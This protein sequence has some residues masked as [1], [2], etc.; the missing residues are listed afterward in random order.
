M[1]ARKEKLA[2]I[3]G[4]ELIQTLEGISEYRL[5]KNGLRI[6]LVPDPAQPVAGCMVTYH[7]GSRN[8]ATGYTGATHLLEHLMFKGSKKFNRKNKNT[9]FELLEKKGAQVNATTW[10]DRTNYYEIFPRENLETAIAIEADRMRN[11]FIEEK[12]RQSEMT[13][14]RNE[15]ESGENSP[16]MAIDKLMWATAFQAHPYHHPT[17]GWKSDIE[18][19]PIERLKQFYDEF[20]WP[21]NATLTIAGGFDEAKTLQLIKKHFGVHGRNPEPSPALYTQEPPQEGQ[22]RVTVERPGFN[23]FSVAYR[24]PNAHH[25]DIP[26]IAMLGLVLA[27]G[28]TSRLYKALVDTG[29]A[30][31]VS[32]S[33]PHLRDPGLFQIFVTPADGIGHAAVENA[34]NAEIKRLGE[35]GV[36]KP[37]LAKAKRSMRTSLAYR[38]DGL[39][40]LLD[41]LNEDIATGD[42]TRFVTMPAR[43]QNVSEKDVVRVARAHLKEGQS[44]VGWFVKSGS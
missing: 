13:V 31:G 32:A 41:A 4:I 22:R 11:A 35:G 7:V 12:A 14:V 33:W 15:Y 27:D 40:S 29:L 3:P 26:G 30:T 21:D 34:L 5:S 36:T 39:Y 1:A 37:E 19:V 25:E 24:I 43:Y 44:T 9:I 6:L 28:K 10:Y 38:R 20:Y 16:Y 8:E 23:V 42:W 18:N 2:K 17:I